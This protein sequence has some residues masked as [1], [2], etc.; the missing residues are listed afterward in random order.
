M[1]RRFRYD[2][3]F[4]VFVVFEGETD[5]IQPLLQRIRREDR[6]VG[7]L[8]LHVQALAPDRPGGRHFGRLGRAARRSRPAA[9]PAGV[10]MQSRCAKKDLAKGE[11]L[12]GEGGYTVGR[13]ADAGRGFAARKAACR[14]ASR[15]AG[16]CCSRSPPASRSG[17]ATW[18]S[19]R[20]SPAVKLRR[21]KWSRPSGSGSVRQP[22]RGTRCGGQVLPA[23]VR[24]RICRSSVCAPRHSGAP[25]RSSRR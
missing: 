24:R 6:S 3:R 8:R 2:I 16:R 5:Y 18:L 25:S 13:P 15:T 21:E 11:I 7:A 9:R 20:T 22:E 1:E 17:G 10:P 12:D 19:T 23:C 14:S 4:G